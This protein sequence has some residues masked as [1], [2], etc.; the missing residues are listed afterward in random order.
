M[1]IYIFYKLIF[2]IFNINIL[3]KIFLEIFTIVVSLWKQLKLTWF[4]FIRIQFNFRGSLTKQNLFLKLSKTLYILLMLYKIEMSLLIGIQKVTLNTHNILD[5]HGSIR[6]NWSV[7]RIQWSIYGV[8]NSLILF[9]FYF[10]RVWG[11]RSST[12]LIICTQWHFLIVIIVLNNIYFRLLIFLN[13][14]IIVNMLVL[15]FNN[16]ID[17]S[18]IVSFLFF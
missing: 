10:I 5:S 8:Q 6:K 1:L 18:L 4:L 11:L 2:I 7:Y 12:R 17:L 16:L 13:V 3:L 9:A 15:T 14:F